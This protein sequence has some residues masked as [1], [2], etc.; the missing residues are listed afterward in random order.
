MI[1]CWTPIE[2]SQLYGRTPHPLRILESQVVARAGLPKLALFQGP[3]R[4]LVGSNAGPKKFCG[5]GLDRSQ[6]G[7][8]LPLLSN[9]RRSVDVTSA[10]AAGSFARATPIES[11]RTLRLTLALIAV[12]PVPSTSKLALTR[13]FTSFQFGTF[14][15]SGALTFRLGS[16]GPGP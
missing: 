9:H 1:S 2:Y 5:A 13:G 11:C 8:W 14:L 10:L 4:S 7:V 16:H 3:H 6:S 15:I 12:F